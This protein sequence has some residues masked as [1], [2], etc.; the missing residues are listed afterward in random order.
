MLHSAEII[1]LG[2]S[3][4]LSCGTGLVAH[5]A[6]GP[7]LDF[8]AYIPK[9]ATIATPLVVSV[10]GLERRALQHA[11]RF[12]KFAE[13][14]GFVVLAPLFSKSR[15]PRYQRLE[16][17]RSGE[18]P[19]EALELTIDLFQQRTGMDAAPLRLFGYSGGAQFAMR[20]AILGSLPVSRLVLAAPGWFTMPDPAQPFPLGLAASQGS[21]GRA[22]DISKLLSIPVLLTVGADD[23]RRDA[24]LNRSSLVDA[25]QGLTRVERAHR[26]TVAM[27]AAAK[28]HEMAQQV[29]FRLLPG[30]GHDF[31][32]N[33]Q[34][35]GLGE[36][37]ARWLMS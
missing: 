31:E 26:W 4:P 32:E 6:E 14:F 19:M 11:V 27:T 15:I 24:S 16:R 20:Y 29:E 12:S 22:P 30:A 21:E 36:I 25:Q 17:G 35:H 10:H 8:F 18:C 34:Q 37:V 23:T 2:Q 9:D 13:Q 3:G 1:S 7:E 5:R 28:R 33:M